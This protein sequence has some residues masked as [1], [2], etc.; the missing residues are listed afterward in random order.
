MSKTYRDD[1]RG[2][3]RRAEN[4]FDNDENNYAEYWQRYY[5]LDCDAEGISFHKEE[6]FKSKRIKIELREKTPYSLVP[7]SDRRMLG[8]RYDKNPAWWNRLCH[9]K[10]NRRKDKVLLRHIVQRGLDRVDQSTI[11][12]HPRKPC[13]YYW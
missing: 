6:W 11:F 4:D 9:T 1:M 2:R 7:R 3:L 13:K 12:S 10:P 5:T 8:W